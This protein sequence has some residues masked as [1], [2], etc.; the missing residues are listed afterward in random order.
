MQS[1]ARAGLRHARA[2]EVS[3]TGGHMRCQ[4]YMSCIHSPGCALCLAETAL[5]WQPW[6]R[7]L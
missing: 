4:L 2:P 1:F 6:I 5:K 3:N 7:V